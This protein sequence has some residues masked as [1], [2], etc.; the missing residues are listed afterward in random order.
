M[1]EGF[2]YISRARIE[3]R[4]GYRHAYLGEVVQ[5]VVYGVQG[6]LR[7]HYGVAAGPPAVSTLDRIVAAAGGW[8]YGTLRGALA[9]RQVQHDIDRFTA[10]VE[11]RIAGPNKTTIRIV[12]IHVAHTLELRADDRDATERAVLVPVAISGVVLRKRGA[13]RPDDSCGAVLPARGGTRSVLPNGWVA[14]AP[15][16]RG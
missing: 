8:M 9:A 10:T 1:A 7:A 5:P 6:A 14:L 4:D 16:R 13:T 12:A 2:E 3:F 11:G 15:K